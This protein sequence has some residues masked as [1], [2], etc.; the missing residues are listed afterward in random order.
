MRSAIHGRD[1]LIKDNIQTAD[2]MVSGLPVGLS[3]IGPAWSEAALLNANDAYERVRGPF[4]APTYRA[5]VPV[6]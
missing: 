5:T 2:L 1:I 6:R 4:R 3:F